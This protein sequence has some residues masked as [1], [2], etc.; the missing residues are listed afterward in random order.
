MNFGIELG[1]LVFSNRIWETMVLELSNYYESDANWICWWF[2]QR[3]YYMWT[4]VGWGVNAPKLFAF[5]IINYDEDNSK[6]N[7]Q[8]QYRLRLKLCLCC[9]YLPFRLDTYCESMLVPRYNYRRNCCTLIDFDNGTI[10]KRNKWL[11]VNYV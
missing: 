8:S 2:T 7:F 3:N 11:G 4:P 5:K 6:V 9:G 1:K 10:N